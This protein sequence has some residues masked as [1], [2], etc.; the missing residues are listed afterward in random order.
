MGNDVI[1][2]NEDV[3]QIPKVSPELKLEISVT[4]HCGQGGHREKT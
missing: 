2:K 3:I 1:L 4:A